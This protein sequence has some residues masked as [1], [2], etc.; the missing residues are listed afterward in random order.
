MCYSPWGCK[1]LDVTERLILTLYMYTHTHTHTHTHIFSVFL[2]RAFPNASC[3][4]VSLC[5]SGLPPP[6]VPRSLAL[7]LIQSASVLS[8]ALSL[9]SLTGLRFPWP[10]WPSRRNPS[11]PRLAQ[12]AFLPTIAT[13]PPITLSPLPDSRPS[14]VA[15][16]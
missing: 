15:V 9:L 14:F 12:G 1:E 8:N 10:P 11:L 4:L 7:S 5:L 13:S 16:T 6:S 3:A 2:W